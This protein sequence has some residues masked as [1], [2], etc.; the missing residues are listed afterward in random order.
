MQE[1]RGREK[2]YRKMSDLMT[3]LGVSDAFY[4]EKGK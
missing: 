3:F 4:L 2:G 1:G